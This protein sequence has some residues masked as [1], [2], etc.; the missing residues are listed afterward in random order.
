MRTRKINASFFLTGNFYRNP[1]FTKVIRRLKRDHHYLGAHSDKHLLY[2]SWS[3]RDSLLVSRNVFETDLASNYEAMKKFGVPKKDARYFLP[4][5]EWYN[6]TISAWTRALGLELI[7]FSSGTISHADYTT[8]DMKDYRSSDEILQSI[9]REG[10]NLNGFILLMHI[11]TD[12]R[13]TD[14]FYKR[15]PGLLRFL[16][17]RQYRFVT[18]DQLLAE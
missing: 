3:N 1:D 11:G 18:V 10:E 8:P 4:P 7:N 15:L 9:R 12:P 17:A 5:Y 13:R 2:C 16:Q 14:K 6:D